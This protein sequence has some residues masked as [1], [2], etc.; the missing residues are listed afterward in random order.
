M[1]EQ[2]FNC[3]TLENRVPADHSLRGIRL[4]TDTVL[5]SLDTESMSCM[6][7]RDDCRS[8]PR[9]ILRASLLQAFYSMHSER[10]L[11]EQLDF[12]VRFHWFVGLS[13]DDTVW[14]YAVISEKR[15]RL[16]NSEVAQPFS[17]R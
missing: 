17:L 10:Q 11:S 3:A 6:R 14:N 1:Q 12:N 8:T 9:Y 7:L 2:T 5:R 13:M 16:L 15:D 4:L